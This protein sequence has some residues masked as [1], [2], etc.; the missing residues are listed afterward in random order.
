MGRSSVVRLFITGSVAVGSMAMGVGAGAQSVPP[1]QTT[2]TSTTNHTT[3]TAEIL[4]PATPC[5]GGFRQ[6]ETKVEQREEV[7]VTT[8]L[9]IGP[10]TI[11]IGE[12]QS[13]TYFVPAG[14]T[15]LNTN[16]HTETFIT[17]TYQTV[18]DDPT[19][20]EPTTSAPSSTAI[21]PPSVITSARPATAV[22]GSPALTG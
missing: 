18:C 13:V 15:N 20:T 2:T 16:T 22:V 12:N 14:T 3:E 4:A 6:V 19:T 9:S 17:T 11:L 5:T 10:A 7:S 21:E 1:T 8:D